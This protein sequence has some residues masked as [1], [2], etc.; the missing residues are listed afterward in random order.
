MLTRM[1]RSFDALRRLVDEIDRRALAARAAVT[2]PF[3]ARV[4]A[5]LTD[6]AV[7]EDD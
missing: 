4:M 5:D 3:V 2:R 1:E 7:K 6:H